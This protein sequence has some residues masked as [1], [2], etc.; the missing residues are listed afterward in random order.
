[1]AAPTSRTPGPNAV[2]TAPVPPSKPLMVPNYLWTDPS[3]RRIEGYALY[4]DTPDVTQACSTSNPSWSTCL[5]S[6]VRGAL[7][8]LKPQLGQDGRAQE[9]L[10]PDEVQYLLAGMAAAGFRRL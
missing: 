7:G 4:W 10:F 5:D 2:P 6:V 1:M 8:P 3:N 9:T